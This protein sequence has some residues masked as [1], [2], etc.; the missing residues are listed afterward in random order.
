MIY[1]ELGNTGIKVSKICFGSLT[2]GP[3]QRNL[4]VSE[5]A[6]LI[7]YAFEKGVNFIDTAELYETN[8]HIAKALKTIPRD[9]FVIA[10][11]CY[12]YSA[13]TAEQSLGKALKELETDYLDVFMLHEQMSVHTIKGHYEAIEYLLRMKEKGVIRAFGISTHYVEAVRAALRYPEIEVIHPIVNINGL[14]IQDGSMADMETA[15]KTFKSNGG[16]IFGMKP[17]G[18]GNLLSSID[19]CFD[20]VLGRDYLDAIAFG[21]QSRDEIDY[22]VNRILGEPIDLNLK[23]TLMKQKKSLQIAEWCTK[24]GACIKKCDHKALSMGSDGVEI[25]R[26]RC[27]L[28]GYCASVCPEFCIKVY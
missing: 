7:E 9:E 3:L 8:A 5:G 27:V 20:F 14:G 6:S 11:K 21:M 15:L 24:C 18:G 1:N 22:N 16:G 26:S 23:N 13:E 17:L 19:A 28:C 4:S 2:M 25:D 10:S 12:A